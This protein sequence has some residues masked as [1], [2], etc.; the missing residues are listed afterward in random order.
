MLAGA[1]RLGPAARYIGVHMARKVRQLFDAYDADSNGSITRE[2][3]PALLQA[4]LCTG[5]R[6]VIH[7][8]VYRCSPRHPPLGTTGHHRPHHDI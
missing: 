6:R 4:G 3:I 1:P 2:E 8:I 7:H 5:A